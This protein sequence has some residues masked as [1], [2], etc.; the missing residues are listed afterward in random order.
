MRKGNNFNDVR[1]SDAN[2]GNTLEIGGDYN[3]HEFT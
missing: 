1:I 3:I 2:T